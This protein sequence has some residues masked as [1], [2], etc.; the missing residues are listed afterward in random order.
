MA[1]Q[2][3]RIAYSRQHQKLRRSDRSGREN[4]LAPCAHISGHAAAL[5]LQPDRAA[6]LDPDA[7]R[8]SVASDIEV[9]P[10]ARRLQKSPRRAHP[11]AIALGDLKIA[12]ALVV[13]AVEIGG[14]SDAALG[15]GVTE[16]IEHVPGRPQILDA[17]FAAHA[18]GFVG[19]ASLIL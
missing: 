2:I 10:L 7:R 19:A 5:I 16:R 8:L 4:D 15:R 1:R 17:Q 6:A 11:P 3:A 13:A 9:R 18:V 14:P 12:D